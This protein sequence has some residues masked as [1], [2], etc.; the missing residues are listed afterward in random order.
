MSRTKMIWITIV[1]VL[2]HFLVIG[3][4]ASFQQESV[5]VQRGVLDLS[6]WDFEKDG[7]IPLDGKWGF[8]PA[9]TDAQAFV[10]VPSDTNL[11]QNTSNMPYHK[12]TYTLTILLPPSDAHIYS[13]KIMSIFSSHRVYVD[14]RLVS[15]QGDLQTH[16]ENKPYTVSFEERGSTLHLAIEMSNP[17]SYGINGIYRPIYFGDSDSIYKK[18]VTSLL[19]ECLY[20]FFIG[21]VLFYVHILWWKKRLTKII[22]LLLFFLFNLL[23]FAMQG[24]KFI[25]SFLPNLSFLA[26]QRWLTIWGIMVYFT[27]FLYINQKVH[28]PRLVRYVGVTMNLVMIAGTLVFPFSL[29]IR[30]I[31]VMAVMEY[32]SSFYLL[33]VVA[34]MADKEGKESFYLYLLLLTFN[35]ASTT[36]TLQ[37][38][39]HQNMQINWIVQFLL[40][41]IVSVNK[42]VRDIFQKEK[43]NHDLLHNLKEMTLLK[44]RLLRITSY[45]F[46]NP[47]SVLHN[48]AYEMQQQA[49]HD[50]NIC[51]IMNVTDRLRKLS[52]DVVDVSQ[53]SHYKMSH[54]TLLSL[55]HVI[56]HA[57]LVCEYKWKT[58]ISCTINVPTHTYIRFN[59]EEM[60][61]I[62]VRLMQLYLR[63]STQEGILITSNQD[64]D[65]IIIA[66]SFHLNRDKDEQ[67]KESSDYRLLA[68][69]L[70][71]NE[72]YLEMVSSAH[73]VV[74]RFSVPL[75]SK[76]EW[77]NQQNLREDSHAI[78]KAETTILVIEQEPLIRET[79]ERVLCSQDVA[80]VAPC[81]N[82]EALRLLASYGQWDLIILDFHFQGESSL[83]ICQNIRETYSL[84]ELPIIMHANQ[85]KEFDVISSYAAGANDFILKFVDLSELKSRI[86]IQLALKK[87]VTDKINMEVAFLQAQIQ[88]HFLFNSLNAIAALSE[89]DHEEM[90][91]LLI[92]FGFYLRESFKTDN[93]KPFVML[94]K[95]LALVEAYMNIEK[96]RFQE[97]LSYTLDVKADPTLQIPPLSIQPLVENAVRH[98]ISKKEEGGHVWITVQETD[99]AVEIIVRDNG[100]GMSSS[101]IEELL[102]LK[103]KGGVGVT[104]VQK[105]LVQRFGKGLTIQ[106]MIGEGTVIRF[107]I[108]NR[109]DDE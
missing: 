104:N 50:A 101:K 2:L 42:M 60:H 63:Y 87:S 41:G 6:K 8:V 57:M 22:L 59:Q 65:E 4:D 98:G 88:P 18:N 68:A 34:R 62:F 13:L 52:N 56:S 47:I 24:E 9:S 107:E 23:F 48:I 49:P 53:I 82:D 99:D 36:G 15:Q 26:S 85:Q 100:V 64:K 28:L 29:G 46:R 90:T 10:T 51:E 80:V 30:F 33:F 93:T 108:P 45:E 76:K 95:E 11:F 91:E 94:K 21:M 12:G 103:H 73:H 20:I 69:L 66:Y 75:A 39:Y 7:A 96:V 92:Q 83:R 40:F 106:S 84:F 58:K 25:F 35:L 19:M 70:E 109:G 5:K 105:R 71:S 3:L 55:H 72:R 44:D 38:I 77:D 27:L 102:S 54:S 16:F 1:I 74:I 78:E 14:G 79:L 17:E 89:I 86:T 31:P 81:T 67:I 97:R 43:Q 32:I 37:F 61:Q